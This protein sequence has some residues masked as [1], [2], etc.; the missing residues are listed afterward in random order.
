MRELLALL[1]LLAVASAHTY[2]VRSGDTLS[3]L[4]A[5]FATTVS[6]LARVN[7]IADPDRIHPG[8]VLTVPG[9]GGGQG[10]G[11]D[12]GTQH[13]VRRG[14]TLSGIAARY[15]VS[16]TDLAE[17]NDLPDPDRILAGMRLDVPGG[18]RCPV[19]G[20]V[21]FVDDYGYRKPDGRVHEGIDLFAPRGSPVVASVPGRAE[22]ITG[23]RGGRQV[24]LHG[25][26]GVLYIAA[27]LESFGAGG[28]VSA[29]KVI[30]TVGTS[31][32][33]RGTRP[34]VHFEVH[35]DGEGPTSPY[36]LLAEACPP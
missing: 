32:N 24:W 31:G 15:G 4:A 2:T 8:Q 35:P 26:D 23:D 10:T 18:W 1:A 5:R 27:H 19:A 33:A 3:A 11:G 34:H 12:V 36:P 30:G 16:V 25:D 20:E 7:G 6:E 29:G 9:G 13:L 14:E 17:A 28:R 21:H 22:Q